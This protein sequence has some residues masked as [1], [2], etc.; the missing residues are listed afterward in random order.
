MKLK[1]SSFFFFLADTDKDLEKASIVMMNRK[2]DK[3][4]PCLNPRLLAKNPASS[5]FTDIEKEGV[6]IQA[7]IH[8]SR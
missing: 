6:V 7:L 4:S 8:L 2:D 3:G 5:P 1:F